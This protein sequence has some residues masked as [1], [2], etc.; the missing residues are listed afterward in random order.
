[1]SDILIPNEFTSDQFRPH[2]NT[3]LAAA[4]ASELELPPGIRPAAIHLEHRGQFYWYDF[5]H[6]ERDS[7]GEVHGWVYQRRADGPF[8]LLRIHNS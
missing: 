5:S 8:Q 1:M 2:L 3:L 4:D 7:Y 6:R